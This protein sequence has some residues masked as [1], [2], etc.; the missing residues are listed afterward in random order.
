MITQP[1]SEIEEMNV[2]R[3][4][5]RDQEQMAQEELQRMNIM[6]EQGEKPNASR[7]AGT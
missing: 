3:K 7:E 1:Q 4:L 6:Q 5:K 2:R